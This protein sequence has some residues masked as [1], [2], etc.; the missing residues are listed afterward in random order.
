[1]SNAHYYVKALPRHEQG[2]TCAPGW[3]VYERLAHGSV[4]RAL[5]FDEASANQIA[6]LLDA[7]DC[8]RAEVM[9]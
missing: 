6:R 8:A 3:A 2:A 7:A 9:P 1:M 5:C 4:A